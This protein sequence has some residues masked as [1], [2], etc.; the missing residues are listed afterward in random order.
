MGYMWERELDENGLHY[1]V[2]LD[3]C[4]CERVIETAGYWDFN[5]HKIVMLPVDGLK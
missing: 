3:R 2:W 4:S 1:L 5:L